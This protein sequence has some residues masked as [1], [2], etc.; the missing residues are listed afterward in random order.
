MGLFDHKHYWRPKTAL[1]TIRDPETKAN[2]GG[3]IVED[4][5]CGSV[6]TIEFMPGEAPVVRVAEA[7]K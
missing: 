4:C 1:N 7:V 2:I 5:S 3:L 6:R